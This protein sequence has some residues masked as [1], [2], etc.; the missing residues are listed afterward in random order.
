MRRADESDSAEILV[1][2]VAAVGVGAALGERVGFLLEQLDRGLVERTQAGHLG[3]QLV[4]KQ[5]AL[6]RAAGGDLD[7]LGQLAQ[8]LGAA[9]EVREIW[10][11]RVSTGQL[12]RWFEEAVERNPPPAPGGK[13]IKLRYITQVN[14]R[15]P[16]FV[17]FGTRVDQ[18]PDS[19]LRD[20]VNGIRKELGFG[21]VPV[22]LNARASRNPFDKDK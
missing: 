13:R 14:V 21:A 3:Q 4:R 2:G 15:P 17:L 16:S 12:N 8:W 9:F 6:D 18:L 5:P 22:R 7:L 1:A 11:K 20:L 19:Y 10:S